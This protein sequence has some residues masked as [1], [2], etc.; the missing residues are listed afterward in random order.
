[1]VCTPVPGRLNKIVCGPGLALTLR[2]ACRKEPGPESLVL[3]T[4]N[5][6]APPQAALI[7]RME[8][9]IR[10][11]ICW[12]V[13]YQALLLTSTENRLQKLEDLADRA[14]HKYTLQEG[15]LE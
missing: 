3:E 5:V 6:P 14:C 15:L 12:G 11:R 13:V 1:M 2:M 9:R 4:V 7:Q 8:T 10:V